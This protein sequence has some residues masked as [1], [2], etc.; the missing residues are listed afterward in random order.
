MG[1]TTLAAASFRGHAYICCVMELFVQQNALF[2]EELA[3]VEN[4]SGS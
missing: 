4:K 2:G 3:S 1:A